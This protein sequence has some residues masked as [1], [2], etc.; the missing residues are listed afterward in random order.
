VPT[1]RTFSPDNAQ[2]AQ[3]I[4]SE[5]HREATEWVGV[6]AN[7]NSGIGNG[8]HLVNRLARALQRVGF[9]ERI[10]WT[11]EERAALV[12]RSAG[13]PRCR[14]LVAV[15]GDGTVSD[16]LNE[17]PSVPVTVLPAGTENLVAQHF[18]LCGDPDE[19]AKTIAAEN[20]IR[21]DV[22]LVAGRRF[23]LMVGFGFDGD[24]VSRHHQ[25]RV[26][27][28]G[29]VRPTHRV[30]YVWPV[31]R[32][33]FSYRFT[34]IAA[35]ILDSGAEESLTG[36]TIFVFNAPRYALGLPFVPLARDDDG[37]LDL[38]VFRKPGPL[39]ALYYLWKVFQGTHLEDPGVIHRRVKRVRVTSQH[40]IPV[41][42][43]GDPGGYLPAQT[44]TD[45][46]AGWNVE[47]IPGTLD[48]IA[49]AGRRLQTAWVPLASDSIA[50]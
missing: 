18:G 39:Q 27:R 9:V 24:I 3:P 32:S 11:P 15:G 33:S 34:P 49:S 44:A 10:A 26:S 45:P 46:A 37:W 21:V 35:Q 8:L 50:R 6:V 13:D 20:P 2:V 19:L 14:C 47:V 22:G 23:L 12:A 1:D 40:S 38:I 43:D 31:L 42:I 30:A 41:Q 16:L 4:S 48:V 25:G 17:Q 5:C 28:S 36:T 29:S 7:R